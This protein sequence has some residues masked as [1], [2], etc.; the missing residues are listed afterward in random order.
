VQWTYCGPGHAVTSNPAPLAS[1]VL[2]ERLGLIYGS[3]WSD[4]VELLL[5]RP[6]A[7]EG[8]Y[9]LFAALELIEQVTGAPLPSWL[10][11]LGWVDE[12]SL[13][14]V[15]T[16]TMGVAIQVGQ[17]RRLHLS[18]VPA[19]TQLALLDID[20]LLYVASLEEEFTARPSG[21]R[22]VLDQIGP[23]YENS[24]LEK[25]K[26]PR[27]FVVRPVRIACQN[28][29]VA[30]GAIAQDST[31]DGLSVP[32]WQTCEVPHVATHEAN[33]ALAALTLCDAFQNGGTME[34]R[35]VRK[36]RILHK[37]RPLDYDGHP[38][39][40]V[41]ASLR[42]FGRTV[43]VTLGGDDPAAIT[44][45]EARALFLAITPMP[46]GL[47][48]RVDDAVQHRAITPERICFLLLSQV[49]REIELDYLLATSGRAPSI[50]G[51]GAEWTDRL[52][53]Q[54]ESESCRAAV[55]T[56]M[57][58][59]RLNATDAAAAD[60][61][62]TVRV[63]E[64]RTKGVE[65]VIHPDD[66]AITFT[67]LDPLDAVPWTR[68]LTGVDTLTVFPRTAITADVIAD[69]ARAD[70]P[71]HRALLVPADVP[72]PPR[73]LPVALLRCPD[74]L[75]DIDKTIEE[76]LLKSRISRG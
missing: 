22:R 56:G 63:V 62:S 60:D 52:A 47:R 57:L 1:D 6:D 50:V 29:I 12:E 30:L 24:H 25:E 73:D 34:I 40:K 11:P 59:R 26:R 39:R 61:N 48:E 70:V 66:A 68:G 5:F 4:E 3:A 45:R 67:G 51:G 65:W 58:H 7:V 55:T 74:R 64:D 38:E 15:V 14:C 23:A 69:V 44:P 36:A 43:G 53:R 18:P 28:V 10:L 27:D 31:F 37:G 32:A 72:T 54:A 35:F 49:W 8:R 41:P 71:G 9:S 13:A 20:P 16:E 19:E 42:R 75:A 33:R 76:R 21:L 46:P 17:V 2:G